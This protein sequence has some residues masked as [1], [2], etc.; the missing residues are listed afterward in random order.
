MTR[1]Y[2]WIKGVRFQGFYILGGLVLLWNHFAIHIMLVKSVVLF[3]FSPM[4]LKLGHSALHAS[5]CARKLGELP[6]V[7][8]RA[9]ES[10]WELS[11]KVLSIHA[12]VYFS[13]FSAPLAGTQQ[14]LKWIAKTI[15]QLFSWMGK[16]QKSWFWLC[17]FGSFLGIL[18]TVRVWKTKDNVGP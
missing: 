2:P 16:K 13:Y 6:Q 11:N 17:L 5:L 8:G 14:S 12:Q 7:S 1:L 9:C 15:F 18:P 4:C 10:K 3:E